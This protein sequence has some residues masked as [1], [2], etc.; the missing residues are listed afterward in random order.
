MLRANR[1]PLVRRRAKDSQLV[2][3]LRHEVRDPRA[4]S[5]PHVESDVT[6]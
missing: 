6:S 5:E 1:E 2:S 3:T 4:A